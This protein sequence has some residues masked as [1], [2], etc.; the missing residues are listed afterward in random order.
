[1]A[2][3]EVACS[4]PGLPLWSGTLILAEMK[5]NPRFSISLLLL[6]SSLAPSA[7][8]HSAVEPAPRNEPWW[9][10]RHK[11]FNKRVGEVG[12]KAQVL[13]IGDAITQGWEGEGKEV[14]ARYYAHRNAI[15]LG[16]GGDRTQHVLWRLDNGNLEGV[17][18]KA[19]VVMIGTLEDNE[20]RGT[21][22]T[23]L[24][25]EKTKQDWSAKRK[26]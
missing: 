2:G 1:M 25:G 22:E 21:V 9:Q 23:E 15:N 13:F 24:N 3:T 7:Y 8:S 4:T 12:E 5:F 16:I 17:K 26:P 11:S 19:A 10:D 18:P 20:I 14:W 6:A